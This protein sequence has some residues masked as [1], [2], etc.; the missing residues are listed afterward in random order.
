MKNGIIG[1]G[2]ALK[3][4]AEIVKIFNNK[5]TDIKEL[6]DA[7]RKLKQ[8]RKQLKKDGWQDWEKTMFEDLTKAYA[9]KLKKIM[10]K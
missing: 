7:R 1:F 3:S 2:D 10:L 5:D 8:F 6:R 9:K 4:V